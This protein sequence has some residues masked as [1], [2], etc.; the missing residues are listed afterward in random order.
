MDVRWTKRYR[1]NT[2]PQ[3]RFTVTGTNFMGVQLDSVEVRCSVPVPGLQPLFECAIEMPDSL[4]LNATETD[5]EPNPF[6]VRYTVTN[7]SKQIG[8]I[9]RVY[10]SFLR[11]DQP[12]SDVAESAEPVDG[13]GSGQGRVADV[14]VGHRVQ[15]RIT[16]RDVRISVTALDDE[17][18]PIECADNVPIANLKTAL[19]CDVRTSE[20]VLRYEPILTEYTPTKFVISATLTNT[21]GANLND[22]VAELE[23]TD[24]SGQDL[25]ELDP[26]YATTRIRRPGA[27]CSRA[28]PDVLVGLPSEDEEHDGRA[29]VL[30]Y[31]IKYGSRETP[32]ITNG[33]EVPV[34]VEPVVAPILECCW[35]VRTRCA[36]CG[37]VQ[38][39]AVLRG[40]ARAEHRT[41]TRGT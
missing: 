3:F 32:F 15:N 12:A 24:P 27:C 39:D 13:S 35:A 2:T 33:C 36:S 6:T 31:N 1:Y 26:D 23:W 7:K 40:R 37:P 38:S 14:R 17:G 34:T 28:G 11:T 29:Q 21:G 22:I 20:P 5:V 18:T 25:V 19:V 4:G 8:M 16:R 41:A 30:T 10:I 9:K